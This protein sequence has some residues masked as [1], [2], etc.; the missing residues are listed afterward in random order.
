MLNSYFANFITEA[1]II[2]DP[3]LQNRSWHIYSVMPKCSPPFVKGQRGEIIVE[4]CMTGLDREK[5][6]VF[7]KK[8]RDENDSIRDTTKLSGI[9]DI[10]SSHMICDFEFDL[11]GYSMNGIDGLAYSTVHV[12]LE[13][14]FSYASYEFMGLDL[15]TIKFEPLVKR[16]L[17]C[18]R[19]KEFSI[20]ITCTGE[21]PVWFMGVADV[22][23]YASQYIVKQELPGG[24]CVVYRTYSSVD[25]RCMVCIPTKLTMQQQCWEAAKEEKE[26]QEVAGSGAVVCQCISS[27]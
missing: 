14:G 27:A 21:V 8:S 3:K 6:A 15:E 22:E 18:F 11:C 19:P 1:Y 12:N 17:S 10:I 26:E 4:M 7:Y 16:L 2:N 13:D 9:V 25:E 20:A 5:A 23:G 24:G